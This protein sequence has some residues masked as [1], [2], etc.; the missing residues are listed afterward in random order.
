MNN[1][2]LAELDAGVWSP[3]YVPKKEMDMPA[4]PLMAIKSFRLSRCAATIQDFVW[5]TERNVMTARL[6][7]QG[8]GER[9]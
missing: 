5:S 3:K 7:K 1:S 8:G 6:Q 2:F 4:R 9:V